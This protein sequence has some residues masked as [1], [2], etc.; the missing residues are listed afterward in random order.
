MS[1]E[2]RQALNKSS[3]VDARSDLYSLGVVLFEM[4]TGHLPKQVKLGAADP[5]Q[6][7]P[8]VSPAMSAIIRK[9]LEPEVG[10]RY[11]TADELRDDLTAQFHREPLVHQP[12]QAKQS[13]C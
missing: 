5:S 1:P 7:N 4:L 11:Q 8:S 2:H 9:C 13:D 6:W 12:S 10:A 3:V